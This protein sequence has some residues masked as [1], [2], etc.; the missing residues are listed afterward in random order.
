MRSIKPLL[1]ICSTVAIITLSLSDSFTNALAPPVG[2]TG[3]PGE[4]TCAQTGCHSDGTLSEF[5][6]DPNIGKLDVVQGGTTLTAGTSYQ[7]SF[8]NGTGSTA[9]GMSLVMLDA[10]NNQAGS[11]EIAGANN[12]HTRL[13]TNANNG[14]IYVGHNN[15]SQG[16]TP[17]QAAR[18]FKWNAPA[19]IN[20]PI[21]VYASMNDANGNGLASGDNVFTVAYRW[22]NDGLTKLSGPV[23]GIK[24]LNADEASEVNIYPNPVKTDLS[25]FFSLEE[26]AEVTA[27]IYNISGQLVKTLVNESLNPGSHGRSFQVAGELSTGMYLVQLNINEQVYFKKIMVE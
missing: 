22:D 2:Y 24:P 4:L 6:T 21:Y 8:N 5:V 26:H 7:L 15:A 10:D 14:R 27:D 12:T 16:G 19:T 11:F 1:F 9:Y 13:D 25:V 20:G 18:V 23:S 3:A 17:T